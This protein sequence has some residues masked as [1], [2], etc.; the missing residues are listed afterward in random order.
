MHSR[1]DSL[2]ARFHADQ[3]DRGVVE[4]A[5]EDT[6]SVRASAHTRVDAARQ[7]A[8]RVEHLRT[9]LLADDRL[10]VRHHLRERV[11]PAHG[12]HDVV[13]V[14]HRLRPVT[15]TRVDRVLQR[16]RALGDGDHLGAELPHPE[17]VRVLAGDVLLAHVDRARE[18]EPR[19]HRRRG[20]A[21]LPGAGLRDHTSLPHALH[22][23]A[24]AH[25]VVGLVGPGVVQVLALDVDACAAERTR[26]VVAVRHRRRPAGVGRHQ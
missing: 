5:G 1:F 21:V 24:L 22:E 2:A 12:P 10:E 16:P 26:E 20:D 13:R 14:V 3:L 15:Q 8:R 25:D 6:G 11:G 7:L 17:D 19:R 9:R 23:Q 18:P 4:E